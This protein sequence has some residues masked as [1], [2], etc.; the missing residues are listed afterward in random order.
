MGVKKGV[1]LCG[2]S[3]S[4]LSPLTRVSNKAL[5]PVVDRPMVYYPIQMMVDSGIRDILLVCGG[6]SVGEFLRILGNGEEF[7]LKGLHYRY[8]S[9]PRGIA[10]ALGLA[11]DWADNEPV[12]VLLSDNI[13]Q[14]PVPNAVS[15]FESGATIF[16]SQVEHPEH[17][18]VATFDCAGQISNIVEKPKEPESNWAVTGFYLYDSSVWEFIRKLE[19]SARGELEITDVNN[20]FLQE[21][22][23]KAEFLQGYWV[24]CGESL[25]GYFQAQTTIYNARSNSDDRSH[26]E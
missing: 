23:L 19:P 12:A 21:G 2:G 8:Q 20:H 11:E 22:N 17:Y 13:F 4:R 15:S 24:D 1:I 25:E 14:Y 16:L 3:G 7:G 10:D 5:L 6:N 26:T 9:E 18:G